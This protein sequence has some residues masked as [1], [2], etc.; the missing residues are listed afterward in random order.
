M[1]KVFQ[2]FGTS[3]FLSRIY[4][5][6]N[7]RWSMEQYTKKMQGKSKLCKV[8]VIYHILVFIVAHGVKSFF[9][10]VGLLNR[11]PGERLCCVQD[12]KLHARNT[13]WH[14][15]CVC[16]M[17]KFMRAKTAEKNSVAWTCH[18]IKTGSW[19]TVNL[20]VGVEPLTKIVRNRIF[21]M[22]EISHV[23]VRRPP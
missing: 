23:L 14:Y 17:S 8:A 10:P 7:C 16:E 1:K 3:S 19:L 11:S 5:I 20:L 15:F 18:E 4:P 13:D 6:F 9:I 21:S 22:L 12:A 2:T